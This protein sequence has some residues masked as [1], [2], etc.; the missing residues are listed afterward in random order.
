MSEPPLAASLTGR[1]DRP[2]L[3]LG[4]SLGTSRRLWDRQA[5]AL[6]ERFRLLRYELPGHGGAGTPPGELTVGRLGGW[7]LDLLDRHRVE[8]AA[9][10]GVSLGGMVGMWLAAHAP[11]RIGP[12]G[13]ICTSAY[14]PPAAGWLDRAAAV[15]SKGMAPIV[16]QSIGR[17]FTPAFIADCPE[18]ITSFAAEL[19][20]A[21]PAGYAACCLAIAGL[22]LRGDLASITAPTLVISGAD[23]PATPPEHGAAIAAGIGGARQLV[24]AGAHLANVSSSG[25]VTAALLDQLSVTMR[26][27]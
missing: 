14:L 12:L 10:C 27:R 20:A 6:S 1:A 19:A 17:W 11:E 23:D 9:Y 16:D 21:D 8:R 7:V 15:L 22:D 5:P 3:V 4:N 18:V 13:L 2:V 25:E 26:W 24:V